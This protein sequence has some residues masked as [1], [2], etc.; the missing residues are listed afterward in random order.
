MCLVPAGEAQV[1]ERHRVDRADCY[2]GTVFGRHV[3]ERR[4]V[5]N[6]QELETR[7]I[8]LDELPNDPELAQS[9]GDGEHQIGGGSALRQAIDETESDDFRDQ[10]RDGLA[11]HRRFRLD[12]ANTPADDAQSV[13]HRG[14]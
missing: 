4:T 6:R 9:L 14:V 10:H 12:S 13:H 11:E 7:S 5:G 2:R 3:A 1:V 8:K